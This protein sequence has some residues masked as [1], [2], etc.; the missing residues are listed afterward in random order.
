VTDKVEVLVS[1]DGKDYASVGFLETDLRWKDLPVN[2][3]WPDHEVI[4]GATFRVV[5]REPVE[6]R[7]VQY[8]VASKR[9]FC[10][11]ELEVLDTIK[12]APYDLRVALPDEK[13]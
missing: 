7:F 13:P 1:K 3:M 4:Q 2:H 8:K 9:I 12:W 10:V 11:T 5:P 6:A